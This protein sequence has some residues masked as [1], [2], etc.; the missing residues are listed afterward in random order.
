MHVVK[1][2]TDLHFYVFSCV[3]RIGLA[4]EQKSWNQVAADYTTTQGEHKLWR[5]SCTWHILAMSSCSN[6]VSLDIRTDNGP[7]L[8]NFL[9]LNINFTLESQHFSLF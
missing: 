5:T 1:S 3:P 8:L 6:K 4:L 7:V 9:I 2:N